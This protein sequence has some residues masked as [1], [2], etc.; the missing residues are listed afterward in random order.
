VLIRIVL[1]PQLAWTKIRIQ[2]L[3]RLMETHLL[4]STKVPAKKVQESVR[5]KVTKE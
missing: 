5:I 4:L 3:I 2:D 1:N